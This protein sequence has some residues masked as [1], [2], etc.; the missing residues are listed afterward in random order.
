MHTLN[1]MAAV[2]MMDRVPKSRGYIIQKE[3][4]S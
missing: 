1:E 2:E 4:N 3:G